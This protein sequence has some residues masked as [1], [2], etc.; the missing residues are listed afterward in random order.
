MADYSTQTLE[1][2]GNVFKQKLDIFSSVMNE[3]VETAMYIMPTIFFLHAIY[4][5]ARSYFVFVSTPVVCSSA[6]G[7]APS[8]F[9]F[10]F[11]VWIER[12]IENRDAF[13]Y[14]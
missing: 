8:K 14:S 12:T 6:P 4:T 3:P 10:F 7:L 9:F 11:L 1:L 2:M 13:F 5:T